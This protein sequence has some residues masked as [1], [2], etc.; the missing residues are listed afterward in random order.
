MRLS[1]TISCILA[2]ACGLAAQSIYVPSNTPTTGTCNAFPFNTTD[3]RYQ[4]LVTPTQMGN[5]PAVISGMAVAQCAGGSATFQHLTI[6]M[7]HLAATTLS[8]TFDT[9]LAAGA[10]TVLDIPNYTWQAAANVWND[11]DLQLPFVYNGTDSLVIDVLALGRNGTIGATYRDST[12]QRVYQG[13]YTGQTTGSSS[14][15]AFKL[16]LI[17]GDATT[18]VFG[19]GCQGSNAQT[20]KLTLSGSSQLGMGLGVSQAN[21]LPSAPTVLHVGNSS[22]LPLFPF[23]LGAIGATGC[24]MYCNAIIAAPLTTSSS[25]NARVTVN[26]PNLPTLVA[27]KLYFQWANLDVAANSLGITTSDYGRALFGN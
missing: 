20:P 13:S 2:L 26:V 9:N 25:G 22:A 24:T 27:Y 6:R 18:W 15:S 14:M 5:V 21:A 3:M 11:L 17:T 23:D 12:N 4:T 8:T 19:Q 10:I 1:T 16:R 7:A